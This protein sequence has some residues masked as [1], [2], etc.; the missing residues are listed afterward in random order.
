MDHRCADGQNIS[1]SFL[2]LG[3]GCLMNGIR[4]LPSLIKATG[5]GTHS[6]S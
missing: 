1:S 6:T 4:D 2:D 3:S 5:V